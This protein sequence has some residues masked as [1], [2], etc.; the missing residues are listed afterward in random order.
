VTDS[1]GGQQ[2]TWHAE[3]KAKSSSGNGGGSYSY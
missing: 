1:F 3:G 2:F